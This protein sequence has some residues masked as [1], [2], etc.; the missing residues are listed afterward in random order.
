V[1]NA[2]GRD[3]HENVGHILDAITNPHAPPSLATANG[4]RPIPSRAPV[5][6]DLPHTLQS[7]GEGMAGAGRGARTAATPP[8][9]HVPQPF[10]N[11]PEPGPKGKALYTYTYKPWEGDVMKTGKD[12]GRLWGTEHPPGPWAYKTDPDNTALRAAR[13]GRVDPFVDWQRI[14]GAAREQFTSVRALG[15]FRGW[16][17]AAGQH[18]TTQPGDLNLKTAKFSDASADQIRRL[19]KDNKGSLAMDL[20]GNAAL[21][22]G[23]VGVYS[24]MMPVKQPPLTPD[25]QA[26]YRKQRVQRAP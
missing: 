22:A 12:Q 4:A 10:R 21:V 14:E 13:T 19:A 3:V 11:L 16:K 7:T 2:V 24:N 25:E 9:G 15:P 20:V 23:G 17:K 8:E 26:R 18:Y 5:P 1:L 6:A